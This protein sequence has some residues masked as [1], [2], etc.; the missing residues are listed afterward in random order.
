MAGGL[1]AS[2]LKDAADI[3]KYLLRGHCQKHAQGTLAILPSQPI[4]V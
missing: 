4:V 3:S 2:R 1:R